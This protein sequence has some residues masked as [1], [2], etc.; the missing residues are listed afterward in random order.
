MIIVMLIDCR[1]DL[2]IIAM[3]YRIVLKTIIMLI[4]CGIA[5]QNVFLSPGSEALFIVAC[6]FQVVIMNIFARLQNT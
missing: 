3:S 1:I 2:A 6:E 5:L 4:D